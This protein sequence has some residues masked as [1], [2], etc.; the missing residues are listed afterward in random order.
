M[1]TIKSGN[2]IEELTLDEFTRW[3][4]LAEA[5][6]FLEQKAEE[7]GVD[8]DKLLKPLAI[9]KYLEERFASMRHDVGIEYRMGN[10]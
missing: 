4:C 5:F 7:L 2:K 6:Y 8:L 1:I 3:A 10:I 9:E